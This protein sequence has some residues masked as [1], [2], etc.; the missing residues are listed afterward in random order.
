MTN[1]TLTAPRSWLQPVPL[2]Y[3]PWNP[4]VHS[5]KGP[6]LSVP[7]TSQAGQANDWTS[8]TPS[9]HSF[10]C[11][12]SLIEAICSTWSPKSDIW[13]LLWV[14][15]V[16]CPTASH[17]VSENP[18]ILSSP[19]PPSWGCQAGPVTLHLNYGNINLFHC[20][21]PDSKIPGAS[22]K[23]KP[24]H[25]VASTHTS[26]PSTRETNP[27]CLAGDRKCFL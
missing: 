20:Q 27:F 2:S 25:K 17:Q 6:H 11:G 22:T 24:A 8:P 3:R 15:A 4:V 14:L 10:S 12:P 9:K 21:H 1:C 7:Q 13:E 26:Q 18:T 23:I 5:R 19:V 16:S